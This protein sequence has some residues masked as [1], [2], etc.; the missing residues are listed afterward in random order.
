MLNKYTLLK[1]C[2]A[3]C[4]NCANHTC[5]GCY[6]T[7]YCSVECQRKDYPSHRIICDRLKQ[8]LLKDM[9]INRS[10]TND[11]ENYAL[12]YFPMNPIPFKVTEKRLIYILKL[13][14]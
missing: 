6:L 9:N 2:I 13:N 1:P 5:T 3:D 12:F 14:S 8:P 4:G 11:D 10:N 7:R